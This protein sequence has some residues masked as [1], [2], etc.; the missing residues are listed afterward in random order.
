MAPPPRAIVI[1][2]LRNN[3][4]PAVEV[5]P[6]LPAFRIGGTRALKRTEGAGFPVH[7]SQPFAFPL[8]GPF[9]D[10]VVPF[11]PPDLDNQPLRP[12]SPI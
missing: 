8:P 9:F 11:P 12:Q 7:D 3:F 2:T 10:F 1:V 4:K 6:P 5:V